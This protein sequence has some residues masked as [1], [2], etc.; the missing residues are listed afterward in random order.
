MQLY[1]S[2]YCLD[3]E[4]VS[5]PVRPVDNRLI[6]TMKIVLGSTK[7][8]STKGIYNVILKN[9]FSINENF[10]NFAYND[11]SLRNIL[12]FTCSKLIPINVRS[13]M[14]K[15]IH[16]IEFSEIKEAKVKLVSPSC[17]IYDKLDISRVY[18]YIQCE[19]VMNI[20]ILFLKV[21]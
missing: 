16:R 1:E 2:K 17:K 12:E 19:K 13:H 10:Q 15:I 18:L 6:L 7:R 4:V 9:E 20:G 3:E 14:W 11:F 8:I 21:F 5:T